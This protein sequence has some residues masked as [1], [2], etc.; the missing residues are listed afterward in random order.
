MSIPIQFSTPNQAD[1]A[2]DASNPKRQHYRVL[3]VDDDDVIRE[4]LVGYLENYHEAAYDLTVE[5]SPSPQDARQKLAESRFDLVITDINMPGEDGFSLIQFI[6]QHY[7]DTR[8][9]MIT[10]YKVED[11]VRN[12]KKTGVF[13]I[14]AKTAPFNFE[15]LSSVVTNLLEPASAFGIETYMDPQCKLSQVI[16]KNSEDIMVAFNALQTFLGGTSI[17][18]PNDLLTA[19][20]EAITNAV[21]HVAKLPNGALKYEKG[22]PIDQLEE[23]EYVYIYYG[24]D[25]ERIGIAIVDQGGRITAD[26]ILYWL[27]RNISGTGLMDTHGR[28]VYLIHR[29]VDRVLINI[30]PGQ[31]TE[32]IIL[33]YLN[34]LYSANKPIYINQL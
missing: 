13:N 22:Q 3:I 21:Y 8:T 2:S 11:Y 29:L 20:I 1:L 34:H 19:V 4:G 17:A 23:S 31:R 10:A 7:P 27:D 18:N 6:K 28:G 26:E 25:L 33:D 9:A 30:A 12:A 14:I 15:E 32:I 5:A 16:I 24:Q